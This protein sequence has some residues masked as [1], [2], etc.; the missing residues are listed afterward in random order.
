MLNTQVK[1]TYA[2]YV[3]L[4]E[5]DRRELIH[6]DFCMVPAPNIRH[7][8]IVA[9]LGAAMR[10]YVRENRLGKVGIAPIDVVLSDENVVQPDILFVSAKRS[11]VI[12]EANIQGAPDLVVEVLSLSTADRDRQL[13]LGLYARFGVREYWIV[14]PVEE[15][16]QVLELG[17]EG[18][19]PAQTYTT[20]VVPSGVVEGFEID[21]SRIFAE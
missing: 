5:Q 8:D 12:T 11:E 13:K 3:L 15:S 17:L 10:Q 20:G 6:G 9:D 7:Q 18:Y 16:V 1:F 19:G 2:D 4:P 21:L 14:D